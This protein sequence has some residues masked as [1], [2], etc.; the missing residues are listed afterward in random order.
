MPRGQAL[1]ITWSIPDREKY[2][3]RLFELQ[4]RLDVLMGGKAAEELIFG[5]RNV[6]SGCTSDLRQATNLARRMVMNFGMANDVD[7]AP[8]FYEPDEY[9][10]LSDEAKHAIDTQTQ[11]LLTN[12][13]QRAA[14]HL[15]AH[16]KELHRLA[17]A[18]I[19][20]ETLSAEEIELAIQGKKKQIGQKRNEM[21]D[22]EA[23]GVQRVKEQRN[24]K[25]TDAPKGQEATG[26]K[27]A[28]KRPAPVAEPVAE[29][30][31]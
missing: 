3:E 21:K 15:K 17:E 22:A 14:D 5:S 12:A 4:A 7:P 28:K 16:E 27:A 19:E 25:D 20:F 26:K 24:Q 11:T 8:I 30:V 1:G 29:K 2:S 6:T 10:V 31:E 9:A 13:Y 18:L 23:A